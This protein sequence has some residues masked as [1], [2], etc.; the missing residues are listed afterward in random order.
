MNGEAREIE[1][2]RVIAVPRGRVFRA[3]TTPSE[4]M[5]FASPEDA[6]VIEAESEPRPGGRWRVVMRG[7]DGS[8][9][10]AVGEYREVETD[11]RVVHSHAWLQP[12]G[13]RTPETIVTVT[14]ADEGE[15]TRITIRQV[16][17]TDRASAEGHRSG[18]SSVLNRLERDLPRD[19][20]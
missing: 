3:W 17:L 20:T 5:H 6:E 7:M 11:R 2:S 8:R 12:D 4:M 14:F 9:H 15:G 13:T 1:V 19:S 18:W 16:Q 10:E